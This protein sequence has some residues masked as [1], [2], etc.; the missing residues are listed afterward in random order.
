MATFVSS[1]TNT[2]GGCK[3][4]GHCFDRR[5]IYDL[6]YFLRGGFERRKGAWNKQAG[7][8]DLLGMDRSQTRHSYHLR[9]EVPR[10][11]TRRGGTE[12]HNTTK[13]HYIW[14]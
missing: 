4:S 3:M 2:G 6:D 5:R 14:L 13:E 9:L 10:G 8:D 1:G 12:K 7:E 11:K